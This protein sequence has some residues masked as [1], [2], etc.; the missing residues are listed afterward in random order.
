M[1]ETAAEY[2][3]ETNSD[4][5]ADTSHVSASMLKALHQSPRIYQ[6]RYIAE[7]IKS[8][9][10]PSMR[11]GTAVHTLALERDRFHEEYAVS[12][13][14]DAR[15]KDHKDWARAHA[16]KERLT[17]K[18]GFTVTK[19]VEGLHRIPVVSKLLEADGVVEESIRVEDSL[20]SAPCKVRAD[21]VLPEQKIILDIKTI[22]TI[23]DRSI[24]YACEDFG[25]HIQDA[26]YRSC[27]ANYTATD[28]DD[29]QMIFAFVETQEPFRCRPV[30]LDADS[31]WVGMD[32]RQSLLSDWICRT[33]S[34]DWSEHGEGE[35]KEVMIPSAYKMR[36][37][38]D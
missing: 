11:L 5:H 2:N 23:S 18:E 30:V 17:F 31:Q 12:P 21:K 6:A 3:T 13:F 29:W 38:N 20:T 35:I 9:E 28:I 37:K 1:T 4:Y 15:K 25:Y 10:T 8:T 19:C 14:S 32:L 24:R 33:E 22:Q 7:T 34:G 16:D 27:W 36:G 26:H